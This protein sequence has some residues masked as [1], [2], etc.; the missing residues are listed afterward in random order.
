[1]DLAKASAVLANDMLGFEEDDFSMAY[2]SIAYAC[3]SEVSNLEPGYH[4][5][6]MRLI[7]TSILAERMGV[8]PQLLNAKIQS[9]FEY[10]SFAES[11]SVPWSELL[12]SRLSQRL[13]PISSFN[14]ALAMLAA[15]SSPRFSDACEY[16]L[17]L[18]HDVPS[19]FRKRFSHFFTSTLSEITDKHARHSK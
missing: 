19:D 9:H 6:S 15:P 18:G 1:M 16:V 11:K 3:D 12:Q 13:S 5:K 8:I 7:A 4:P 17:E 2:L 14:I 10:T